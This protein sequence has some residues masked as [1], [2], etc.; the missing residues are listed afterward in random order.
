MLIDYETIQYFAEEDLYQNI[1]GNASS[2]QLMRHLWQ[3][4]LD[5]PI[6]VADPRYNKQMRNVARAALRYYENAKKPKY[7]IK[8]FREMEMLQQEHKNDIGF[9]DV[10]GHTWM[11]VPH[12]EDKPFLW[13]IRES[14]NILAKLETDVRQSWIEATDANGVLQ[15]SFVNQN[16][17][18]SVVFDL[19]PPKKSKT[20][21]IYMKAIIS[22]FL[23]LHNQWEIEEQQNDNE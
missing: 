18:Q 19:F 16:N 21:Y 1:E 15:K 6:E 11:L 10:Q 2:I 23:F 17:Y 7:L 20:N 12:E 4:L 3:Q 9:V 5:S 14:N 8:I 22:T 13:V